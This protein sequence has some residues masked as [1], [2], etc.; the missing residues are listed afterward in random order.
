MQEP[1]DN[2]G[3]ILRWKEHIVP[4][5]EHPDIHIRD[6]AFIAVAWE[7]HGRPSELHELSFGD[8]EDRD[9]HMAIMFTHPDGCER[10]LTLCGSMPYL[11]RWVEAEHP[12]AELLSGDADPIEDADPETPLWTQTHANKDISS[13]QSHS[14]TKRACN[15]ADVPTEFTLHDIRRSRAKLLAIQLGLR[16]PALRRRFGWE[17][18]EHKEFAETVEENGFN[19]GVRPRP[20]IQCP[21]CGSWTPQHQS[22][23]WCEADH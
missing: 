8:V 5:L 11:K 3:E 9:D 15:R 6:K 12:V 2:Q 4:I 18:H 21:E 1:N 17:T 20:P 14:I 23:L 22:C 13:A 7:L 16:T 19:E 10:L